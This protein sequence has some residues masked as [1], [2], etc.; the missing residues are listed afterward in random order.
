[1]SRMFSRLLRRSS[2]PALD[3]ATR[4]ALLKMVSTNE[5]TIEECQLVLLD[6]QRG[7]LPGPPAAPGEPFAHI[8]V[9]RYKELR[10]KSTSKSAGS[11]AKYDEP[12]PSPAPSNSSV[13]SSFRAPRGGRRREASGMEEDITLHRSVVVQVGVQ[14]GVA[15]GTTTITDDLTKTTDC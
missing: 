8:L 4:A 13:R 6:H 11:S 5:I 9:E 15:R 1:M 12:P 7:L 3:H 14:Q 10:A 2:A